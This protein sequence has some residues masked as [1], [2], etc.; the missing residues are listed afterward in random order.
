MLMSSMTLERERE[1]EKGAGESLWRQDV[2]VRF[3]PQLHFALF[4]DKSP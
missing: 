2:N 4:F 1:K 3:L